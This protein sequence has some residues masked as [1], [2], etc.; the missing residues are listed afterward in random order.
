MGAVYTRM[1]NNIYNNN[2]NDDNNMSM[3]RHGLQENIQH[4]V[5]RISIG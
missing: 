1:G 4:K 2:N 3:S 5:A